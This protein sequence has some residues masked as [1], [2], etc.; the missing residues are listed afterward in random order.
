ML[1]SAV[2]SRKKF[3][4]GSPEKRQS[5]RITFQDNKP[6]ITPFK[7][8]SPLQSKMTVRI[9]TT[10]KHIPRKSEIIRMGTSL[11]TKIGTPSMAKTPAGEMSNRASPIQFESKEE[12]ETIKETFRRQTTIKPEVTISEYDITKRWF[13]FEKKIGKDYKPQLNNTI[14]GA[15]NITL[16]PLIDESNIVGNLKIP[17]KKIS[18][19]NP[20]VHSSRLV[21]HSQTPSLSNSN[22]DTLKSNSQMGKKR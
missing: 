2:L 20:L 22:I 18:N 7:P 8:V 15:G 3:T 21:Y 16:L 13:E 9:N 17:R 4:S 6:N 12:L 1:V 5:M 10:S 11:M 19:A 14:Y